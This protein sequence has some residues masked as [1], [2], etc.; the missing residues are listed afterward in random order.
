MVA[1]KKGFPTVVLVV[2]GV[3]AVYVVSKC[4]LAAESSE[5]VRAAG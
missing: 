2:L 4:V 3:I 5:L 1:L